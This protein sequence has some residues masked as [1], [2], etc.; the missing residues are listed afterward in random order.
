MF[1]ISKLLDAGASLAGPRARHDLRINRLMRWGRGEAEWHIL[2]Q[3]VDPS[4]AAIDVGANY[5]DY[6]ARLSQLCPKVFAF[7]PIPWIAS[8]L[9][10]RLHSNV[11]VRQIALSDRTGQA[12]L[13]IPVEDNC[14]AT[15]DH[16]NILPSSLNVRT[17]SCLM[18]KLDDVVSGPV[19]FIKIDVEGHEL[20][21]LQGALQTVRKDRPTLVIESEK[22][23]NP[24]CPEALFTLLSLEGY[25]PYFL[26]NGT[27]LP[28]SEIEP[29][30]NV[31]NFIFFPEELG[32]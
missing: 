15:L 8:E 27:R 17:V 30:E 9:T 16:H 19:G 13:R 25:Q 6:A 20:A 1:I 26:R 10:K 11:E 28:I 22:R 29:S 31:R 4:R 32:F 12:E 2:D 3:L 23:H 24:E 18:A 7:E 21:V 14:L 5:G